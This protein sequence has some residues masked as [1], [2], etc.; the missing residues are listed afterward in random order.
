MLTMMVWKCEGSRVDS[1]M[2][3]V[4]HNGTHGDG[5]QHQYR[6]VDRQQ[7]RHH[8]TRRRQ[9]RA[10]WTRVQ[11]TNTRYSRR[12]GL[13]LFIYCMLYL[14]YRCW[15]CN[16]RKCNTLH[17]QMDLYC[18]W[19]VSTFALWRNFLDCSLSLTFSA[20]RPAKLLLASVPICRPNLDFNIIC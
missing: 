19:F 14:Q 20:D 12:T 8:T 10:W 9:S 7:V 5:R 1:E 3:A 17:N 15:Y 13:S 16:E 6:A 18:F 11:P 2:P 4:R